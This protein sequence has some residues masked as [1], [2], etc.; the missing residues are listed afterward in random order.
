MTTTRVE[1]GE[2]RAV[3]LFEAAADGAQKGVAVAVAVGA[4]LVAFVG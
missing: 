3:N 4:M 2:R 1:F